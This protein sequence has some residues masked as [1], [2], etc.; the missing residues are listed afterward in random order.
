MDVELSPQHDALIEALYDLRTHMNPSRDERL[1]LEAAI[2]MLEFLDE[3]AVDVSVEEDLT[4]EERRRV[5]E[6]VKAARRE[7]RVEWDDDDFERLICSGGF[8]LYG[9]RLQPRF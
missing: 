2:Q 6:R 4:E 9:G 1:I 3:Y 5:S 7:T 8:E